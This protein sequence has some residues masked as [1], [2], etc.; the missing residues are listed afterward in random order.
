MAISDHSPSLCQLNRPRSGLP[1]FVL[2]YLLRVWSSTLFISSVSLL[3][4][5]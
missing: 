5:G 1:H 3:E 2:P 4:F